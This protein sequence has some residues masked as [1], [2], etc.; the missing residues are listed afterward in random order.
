MKNGKLVISLDF[1]LHWGFFDT[2]S[3]DDCREQLAQVPKVIDTLIRLGDQYKVS[4]TFATVGFLFAEN[5]AELSPYLPNNKPRY[6]NDAVN[7]HLLLQNINSKDNSCYFA[8]SL[9]K[10]IKNH[11]LHEIGTHTFSHYYCHENG[12]DIV[13][14]KDDIRAA[15]AI[16]KS[17]DIETH[18]IVFPRN[19]FY[20][21]YI[22]FCETIGIETYRGNCWYNFNNDERQL[23]LK[24]YILKMCRFVDSYINISGNNSYKLEQHNTQNSSI[25]NIPASRFLRPYTPAIKALKTLK[26]NRIKKSM[27]KAAKNNEVYHLWFHPHNFAKHTEEN[28]KNLESIFKHFKE[29]NQQYG[30]ESNTMLELARNFRKN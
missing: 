14:F 25:V 7:S 4:I 8:K 21:D 12:Q 2:V 26:L 28:F 27:T 1:E 9:V 6:S 18:S 17:L 29:L 23:A 19:Q 3:L 11:P 24:E 30:F 20:P 10:K 22:E 16:A 13:S 15:I 5:K